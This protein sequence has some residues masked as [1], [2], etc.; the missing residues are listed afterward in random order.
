MVPSQLSLRIK[1]CELVF[2]NQRRGSKLVKFSGRYL[3]IIM[4]NVEKDSD[5][6]PNLKNN[7][8]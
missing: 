5:F 1:S 4:A 3:P 7:F 8:K 2:S 6:R